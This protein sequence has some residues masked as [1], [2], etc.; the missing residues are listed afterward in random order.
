MS[1]IAPGKAAPPFE[2][3]DVDGK[4]YS[5]AAAL[6]RSPVLA[7]FFKVS[8]PTCQYAL[9]FVERLYQQLRPQDAAIWGVSQDN[10][11]DSQRFASAF[12]LTFPILIDEEPYEISQEYGLDHVPTLFLIAPGGQVEISGDGFSKS[13]LLEIQ[14]WL[15][16]HFAVEAPPLFLPGEKVPE[17]KP[18]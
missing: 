5:L 14:K 4:P 9:P 7:A 12:G 1:A 13:D 16:R 18:G 10:A 11:R 6:E 2:L 17:Y 15:A 8:C 3:M